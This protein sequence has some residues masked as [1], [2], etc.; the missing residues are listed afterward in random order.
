MNS[1]SPSHARAPPPPFAPLP[2][3]STAPPAP[4][5]LPCSP[6]RR[7]LLPF[8]VPSSGRHR[9][10]T[11]ALDLICPAP[12]PLHCAS[13]SAAPCSAGARRPRSGLGR[14]ARPR[15]RRRGA[16]GYMSMALF[17][18]CSRWPCP[19]RGGGAAGG[20]HPATKVAAIEGFLHLNLDLHGAGVQPLEFKGRR[21]G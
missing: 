2:S 7:L 15:D 14:R 19:A 12:L 3:L 6:P 11:A 10:T 13:A 21:G 18:R 1:S 16:A 9:E 5:L 17:S 20:A 4:S 8:T